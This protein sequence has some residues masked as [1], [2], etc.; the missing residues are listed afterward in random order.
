MLDADAIKPEGFRPLRRVEYERLVELGAFEDERVELLDGGLVTM[1]PQ[2]TRHAEVLRRL[3]RLFAAAALDR[4][5]VQVQSPLGMGPRSLPE[6]DLAVVPPGDY[7]DAHPESAL[8]VVEVADSSLNKDRA[9]AAVYAAGGVPEYWIINLVDNVVE[10]LRGPHGDRYR[11]VTTAGPN[12]ELGPLELP[13][14]TIR[15][16]DLLP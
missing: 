4:A 2:G 7:A 8:L 12:D 9:K 10:V 13:A 16:S 5:L 3:N 6:P 1:S 15:V 14:L 11:D